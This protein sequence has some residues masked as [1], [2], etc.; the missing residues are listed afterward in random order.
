MGVF[1]DRTRA[2]ARTA[3][4]AARRRA[5]T[6]RARRRP[7]TRGGEAR[8]EEK[9]GAAD[10]D[11]SIQRAYRRVF[12]GAVTYTLRAEVAAPPPRFSYTYRD[13]AERQRKADEAAARV[14]AYERT[15]R[16]LTQRLTRRMGDSLALRGLSRTQR[17][18]DYVARGAPR[19]VLCTPHVRA[20]SERRTPLGE[21]AETE[22][23]IRV[24]RAQRRPLSAS[25]K[26]RLGLAPTL[27][28]CFA[29]C[30]MA[31]F[32]Y[33]LLP[34]SVSSR[35]TDDHACVIFL[36]MAS[37][38]DG[39]KVLR[40]SLYD[41][42][43]VEW[44]E[45]HHRGLGRLRAAWALVAKALLRA[46]RAPPPPP[47]PPPPRRAHGGGSSN[48]NNNEGVRW[49]VDPTVRGVGSDLQTWAGRRAG[50]RRE[51]LGICAA[52]SLWIFRQWAESEDIARGVS[53]RAYEARRVAEL[54]H[55]ERGAA[56][57]LAVKRSVLRF[58]GDVGAHLRTSRGALERSVQRDVERDPSLRKGAHALVG[59]AEVSETDAAG[60][61]STFQVR[62]TVK[63]ETQTL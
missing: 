33:A 51:G 63:P 1:G 9:G 49:A 58:I 37:T 34:F 2:R 32:R 23:A 57:A 27:A 29:R 53:F 13:E 39:A 15:T 55:M 45:A 56:A 41:P 50:L 48:N 61:R 36:D 17:I 30:R 42:N 3:R 24:A 46:G 54:R 21:L 6:R 28:Y 16:A 59:T 8:A 26:G 5:H 11:R 18:L 52:I 19:R 4:A 43:G 62:V 31:G 7:H 60:G 40:C 38:A 14:A 35:A 47:P 25:R 10:L 44:M 20:L 22:D 12:N